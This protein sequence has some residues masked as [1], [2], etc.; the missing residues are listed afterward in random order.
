MPFTFSHPALIIPL[1]NRVKWLSLTGLITGSLAPDFEYFIRMDAIRNYTHTW[2]SIFY[3]DLTIGL[4]LAFIYHNIVRNSFIANLPIALKERLQEYA[5]FN[6]NDYFK[7]N[8]LIIIISVFI[9]SL[10]HLFW[11]GFTHEQGWFVQL[12]PRMRFEIRAAQ[13]SIPLFLLLQYISSIVGLIVI[14]HSIGALPRMKAI[15]KQG[16]TWLYWTTVGLISITIFAY[17]LW[18]VDVDAV[19]SVTILI[20]F[21]SS[22]IL[23]LLGAPLIVGLLTK[24]S[25]SRV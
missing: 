14:C 10:L 11:D 22:C 21:N 8:F 20:F 4:L 9:G 17:K 6:W 15:E 2:L 19:A 18:G 5:N 12:V 7:K 24:M 1:Y 13:H 23:G 16:N 3:I 25:K